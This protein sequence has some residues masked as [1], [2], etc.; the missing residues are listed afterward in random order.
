[1][2]LGKGPRW[3][4]GSFNAGERAQL[5]LN[6]IVVTGMIILTGADIL[7]VNAVFVEHPGV[8]LI[9]SCHEV[10]FRHMT[11]QNV[12]IFGL[13]IDAV[14]TAYFVDVTYDLGPGSTGPPAAA[15]SNNK[16]SRLS[17]PSHT[18]S[19]SLSGLRSQQRLRSSCRRDM[20]PAGA[21]AGGRRR[22]RPACM[23][24][25]AR[26]RPVLWPGFCCTLAR[27]KEAPRN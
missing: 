6:Y 16:Q 5:S 23:L 20:Q 14:A 8:L 3:G 19:L 11:L 26:Q 4:T 27:T 24:G 10:W 17:R 9:Y 15:F 12:G 2:V 25:D 21:A 18:H 22:W 13:S 7:W 1:M